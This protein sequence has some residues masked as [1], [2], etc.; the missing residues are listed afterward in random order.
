MRVIRDGSCEECGRVSR[1]TLKEKQEHYHS[2]AGTWMGHHTVDQSIKV[3]ALAQHLCV[4]D[5]VE[6]GWDPLRRSYRG[7]KRM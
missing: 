2:L 4:N 6:L 1:C 5:G 3:V 7:H